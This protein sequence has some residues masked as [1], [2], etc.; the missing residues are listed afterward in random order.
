MIVCS[1][2]LMGGKAV[3]LE[4]GERLV[5]ER[6]DAVAL[7]ERFGRLGE[8][9]VI[10]LD[11]ARETGDNRALIERLCRVARI[12]VGGGIRD[13]E[14]A[15]GYLRAGAQRVI[16]GTAASPELLRELP[17][18]RTIVALDSRNGLVTTNG[19]RELTAESPLE[20]ARRLGPYC[21][22]FLY[23]D[24][25]REGLLGGIDVRRIEELNAALGAPLTFAGGIR[26]VDEIRALDAIGVDAQIGMAVYTGLVDPVDAFVASIDFSRGGGLA[27]TVVCDARGGR[28][29]MVANSTRESLALA[30]REGAGIYWSRSRA[31]LWRKGETSGARQRLVRVSADCDRDALV[32]YVEQEGPTC[33]SGAARCFGDLSFGWDDLVDRIDRRVAGGDVT[34]YTRRLADDPAFLDAKLREEIGEVVDA[35]DRDNLAWECA[36]VLYFLSVKMRANGIGIADVMAQ[37]ASRAV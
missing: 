16:L 18:E 35:T 24:V 3:Q 21:G 29:R 8:I 9:A 10:D 27:P 5:L 6:D 36:D 34:S 7:A 26:S 14:R 32:F 4:R 19:W 31:S 23:T 25:E 1:I 20:R 17:R 28:V 11:A 15:R 33:H 30:L 37:L 13:V 22:G 12:R 2:D